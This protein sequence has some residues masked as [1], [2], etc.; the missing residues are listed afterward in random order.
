VFHQHE[1]FLLF[2]IG[3]RL[4]SATPKSSTTSLLQFLQE[5]DDHFGTSH[6]AINAVHLLHE[7]P[8]AA[9]MVTSAACS[10]KFLTAQ[11]LPF[12]A[13]VKN[14]NHHMKHSRLVLINCF[15]DPPVTP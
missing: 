14:S 2:T 10:A 11:T 4:Q 12:N 13:Y 1:Q 15:V 5:A 8:K 7:P 6:P 9:A 3:T